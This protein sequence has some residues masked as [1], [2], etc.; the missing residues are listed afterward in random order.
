MKSAQ[1]ELTQLRSRIPEHDVI[2]NDF[3]LDYNETI[4]NAASRTGNNLLHLLITDAN[5]IP[6]SGEFQ[7]MRTGPPRFPIRRARFL[8]KLDEALRYCEKHCS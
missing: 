3:I 2:G 7:G 6:T 5:V 8:E 4:R 1:Q